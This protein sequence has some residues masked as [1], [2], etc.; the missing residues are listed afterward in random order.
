MRLFR[1]VLVAALLLAS[2]SPAYADVT[3]F[4]GSNQTPENR[5]FRGF[6][7]AGSGMITFEFEYAGHGDDVEEGTPGLRTFMGNAI[8]QTPFAV[9]GF[10]P[11]V[12]AGTGLYRESF[13]ERTETA[14]SFNSGAGVKTNIFGPIK[15]RVDYRVLKLQGEPLYETVHRVYSGVHLTF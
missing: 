6:A 15:L 5:A 10:Q 9:F 8:L 11:Y 7:L 2:T 1:P 3:F 12:T 4:L 14:W 13:D